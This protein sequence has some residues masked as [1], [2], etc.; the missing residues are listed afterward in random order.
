MCVSILRTTTFTLKCGPN[1]FSDPT[2][3]D[4]TESGNPLCN[5]QFTFTSCQACRNIALCDNSDP[6]NDNGG[7]GS[8]PDGPSADSISGGSVFL[9]VFFV[10][11]FVYC[12]AGAAYQF[13]MKDSRGLD[14]IPNLEF[15]K[16]LPFLIKDGC[17]FCYQKTR[18]L[19][20]RIT[21][22]G[23]STSYQSY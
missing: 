18:D 7:G 12:A 4:A 3:F 22:R 2:Y 9:I 1:P 11:L 14:L 19:I 6:P 5:Y 13:K 16:D 23:G 15:W 17:V 8:D 20:M 10:L 21:S